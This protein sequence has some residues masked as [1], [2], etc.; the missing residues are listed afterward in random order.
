[1]VSAGGAGST[2]VARFHATLGLSS[3]GFVT[4]MAGANAQALTLRRTLVGAAG[5]GAALIGV[6]LGISAVSSVIGGSMRNVRDYETAF[7]GIRKTV[8]ATEVEFAALDRTI[9]AMATSIPVGRIE[10]ARI[11][12][13]AGQLGIRG[14]DN[15]TNFIDTIARIGVATDL[16][17]EEA[18][19]GFARFANIMQE[20]IDQ[21]DNIASVVVEL[22]NNFATFEPEI[23]AF[24]TRIAGAGAIVGF[25]ADQVL[26]L[27]AT[28]PSLGVQA[29]AG[30]TAMQR[31][32]LAINKF[33]GET[34]EELELLATL[35]GQTADEF[36]KQWEEDAAGAFLAF[37]EGLGKAGDQVLPVLEQL[38]LGAVRSARSFLVL[39]Q[40]PALLA[41]AFAMAAAEIETDAKALATESE[42]AFDTTNSA[43]LVFKQ[44]VVELSDVIGTVLVDALNKALPPLTEFVK[45]LTVAAGPEGQVFTDP[46]RAQARGAIA[47]GAA[48]GAGAGIGAGIGA[49]FFGAGA[50]PGAAIGA[51]VGLVMQSI[52]EKTTQGTRSD[53]TRITPGGA[54]F[55]QQEITR[56]RTERSH[57]E[58]AELF[59][60]I[61][62]ELGFDAE[63]RR[64]A[65]MRGVSIPD[66]AEQPEFTGMAAAVVEAGLGLSDF[67]QAMAD[68]LTQ[69]DAGTGTISD[70]ARAEEALRLSREAAIQSIE[71]TLTTRLVEAFIKGGDDAVEAMRGVNAAL[72]AEFE[73]LTPGIEAISGDISAFYFGLFLSMREAA[74][75]V[76][77]RDRG[78][79]GFLQDRRAGDAAAAAGGTTTMHVD[80]INVGVDKDVPGGID[81]DAATKV[82]A[83]GVRKTAASE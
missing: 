5:L 22:G 61:E 80:T 78:L 63:R 83:E 73:Q 1:M 47:K 39:A 38:G 41:K 50:I 58:L 79:L 44:S 56:V 77:T 35:T 9:R 20:P 13:I 8:D 81:L 21:I 71:D 59:A 49:A 76:F 34:G 40:N 57:A 52:L 68:L 2:E 60:G 27:A 67:E 55:A 72:L 48:I 82:S 65:A 45:H 12:Q 18:A 28:L 11:G 10:L 29:E 53:I 36:A 19:I 33:V 26:A 16:T 37:V 70:A 62:R 54:T 23:L 75:T 7:V 31:A 4:G 6:Q 46:Q 66:I 30:G 43:V 64:L 25:T 42:R 14:V 24:S 74:E 15:I 3:A 17:T 32:L 51:G 69:M